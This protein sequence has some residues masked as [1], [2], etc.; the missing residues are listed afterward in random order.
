M[1]SR[2]FYCWL[3]VSQPLDAHVVGDILTAIE[4]HWPT[5]ALR[6][7]VD[8]IGRLHPV[9][10]PAVWWSQNFAAQVE[11]LRRALL[12]DCNGVEEK[13]EPYT[14]ALLSNGVEEEPVALGAILSPE[15]LRA[16]GKAFTSLMLAC[17][18]TR[19]F[20]SRLTSV[21]AAIGQA[22]D[23]IRGVAG[24]SISPEILDGS[25]PDEV[26]PRQRPPA[27]P[28]SL[29]WVSYWSME[30]CRALGFSREDPRAALFAHVVDTGRAL[31]LQLTDEPL[32]LARPEHRAAATAAI[33]AFPLI[34][35]E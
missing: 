27:I 30:T 28:G 4:G 34:Y 31:I 11:R 7:R 24:P 16:D 18:A 19:P 1:T 8:D 23:I 20:T 6:F 15:E 17:P 9:A 22:C 21:L 13:D 32:D 2:S 5:P 26:R 14:P 33:A 25:M 10:E 3:Y 29:S 35:G 12:C